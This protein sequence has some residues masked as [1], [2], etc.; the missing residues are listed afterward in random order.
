MAEGVVQSID[1]EK[2]PGQH[3]E[4]DDGA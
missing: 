1:F 4:D 3:S 2:S